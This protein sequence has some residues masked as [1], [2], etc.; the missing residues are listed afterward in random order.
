MIL[1]HWYFLLVNNVEYDSDVCSWML[2]GAHWLLKLLS[3]ILSVFGSEG[4]EGGMS[5][6]K[7]FK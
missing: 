2:I 4:I 7:I 6:K 5:E 3:I 1:T